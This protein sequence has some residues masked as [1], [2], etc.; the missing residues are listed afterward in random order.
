MM[1]PAWGVPGSLT[2]DLLAML[3]RVIIVVT[4]GRRE[5]DIGLYMRDF[6]LNFLQIM[7]CVF[8]GLSLSYFVFGNTFSVWN[9]GFKVL[10]F[11]AYALMLCCQHRAEA[12]TV[13]RKFIKK[14]AV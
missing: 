11:L 2:A 3:I 6:L 13:L 8:G 7:V 14:R 10:A 1:I 4:I 9:F 5:E 12:A